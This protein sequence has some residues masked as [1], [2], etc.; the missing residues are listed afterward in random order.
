[1]SP[2]YSLAVQHQALWLLSG[3]DHGGINLQTVR[4]DEGKRITTL[5]KHTSAVSVMSLSKDET[6]LLSGSWDK[7]IHDWDL[8]TGQVKRSFLGSGGQISAIEIRPLSDM[9][10][11]RDF[12]EPLPPSD[13][14]GTDS[15]DRRKSRGSIVNGLS[16]GLSRRESAVNGVGSPTD[17]LFGTGDADSLFGDNDTGA[18]GPMGLGAD[19]DDKDYSKAFND[20]L[21]Q[22]ERR[23]QVALANDNVPDLQNGFDEATFSASPT[24]IGNMAPVTNGEMSGPRPRTPVADEMQL[25]PPTNVEMETNQPLTAETIFLDAAIDGTL[26]VWDRRQPNPIARMV[27]PRGTR[28][29]CMHA[30]WSQD[31]NAIY[32]GR[33]NGTVDEYSLHKGLKEPHRTLTFPT[34]SGPV[35]AVRAMPNGKHLVW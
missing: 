1:M 23:E 33:W 35:S 15:M 30:C 32:A 27:P 20:S 24:M 7:N 22:Q 16:G 17:S 5:T 18:D 6:S 9:P 29:W 2:V 12:A 28:P 34:G 14:F 4:H 8:N 31:G 3:T 19:E 10:V 11:P 13:T 26:R 21:D 25:D